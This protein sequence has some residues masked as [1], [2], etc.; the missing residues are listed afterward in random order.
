MKILG[1]G[2]DIVDITRFNKL[3]KI[4]IL[5]KEYFL[6]QKYLLLKKLEIKKHIMQKDLLLKKL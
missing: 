2:V 5:L 4:I 6:T 3:I 1:I